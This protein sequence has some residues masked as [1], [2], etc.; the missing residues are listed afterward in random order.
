MKEVDAAIEAEVKRRLA[1]RDAQSDRETALNALYEGKALIGKARRILSKKGQNVP[2]EI[3]E[4]L[5]SVETQLD[6]IGKADVVTT[7]VA[8]IKAGST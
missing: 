5:G 6:E 2:A 4:K 8:E 1:E 7:R 3:I